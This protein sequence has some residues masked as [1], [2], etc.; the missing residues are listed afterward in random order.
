MASAPAPAADAGA[1]YRVQSTVKATGAEFGSIS[2]NALC[3]PGGR[4]L[5]GG[6]SESSGHPENRLLADE[7]HYSAAG[8]VDGWECAAETAMG[9][10]DVTLVIAVECE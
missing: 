10:T 2:G 1:P 3:N 5:L 7:P 8:A 9:A 4:V 6:C